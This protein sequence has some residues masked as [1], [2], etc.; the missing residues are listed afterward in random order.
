MQQVL[1]VMSQKDVTDEEFMTEEEEAIDESEKA[2]KT[3]TPVKVSK[4]VTSDG[5]A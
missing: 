3:I 4:R 5:D 1:F 2:L